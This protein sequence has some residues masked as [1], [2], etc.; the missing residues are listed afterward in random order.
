M[1]R[2]FSKS[3]LFVAAL[4]GVTA[5]TSCEPNENNVNPG[6][7]PSGKTTEATIGMS[8]SGKLFSKSSPD[9]INMGT[10][11]KAIKNITVVPM[12]GENPQNAILLPDFTPAASANSTF[13]TAAIDQNVDKFLV[14]GG[15]ENPVS[16]QV[17]ENTQFSTS[18]T[19]EPAAATANPAFGTEG[20]ELTG[21]KAPYSLFYF[22]EAAAAATKGDGGFEVSSSEDEWNMVTDWDA[23]ADGKVGE[24]IRVKIPEVRYAVGSLIVGL[25]NGLSL[26][27]TTN[28]ASEE[29]QTVNWT[30]ALANIE[31]VSMVIK[32]QPAKLDYKFDATGDAT[33]DIY[34]G[35]NDAQKALLTSQLKF[36]DSS[37][38]A[39]L[40]D[41]AAAHF[42]SVVAEE[43]NTEDVPLMFQLHYKGTTAI[44]FMED[45]E[46]EDSKTVVIEP[47]SYF[48]LNALVQYEAEAD[49]AYIFNKTTTTL[50]NGNIT[51]WYNAT[52]EPVEP[53]EAQVGIEVNTDWKKGHVYDVDM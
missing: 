42:Y 34:V 23:P 28:V 46:D 10:T 17:G 35:V 6:N 14:Y 11:M 44:K 3:V 50:V 33:A 20:N 18:I 48:Y 36:D 15:S 13:K 41:G 9:D 32:S 52:T 22:K 21:L 38:A 39:K 53:T 45:Y 8:V 4:A 24:N 5:L 40:A 43:A 30:D 7:Q 12:I 16:A 19:F 37:D 47:N 51:R 26:E 49:I 1:K 2:T 29:G 31:V 27:G 25:R